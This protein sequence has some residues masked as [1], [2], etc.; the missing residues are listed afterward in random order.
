MRCCGETGIICR[1]WSGEMGAEP[2]VA[3]WGVMRMGCMVCGDW[4]LLP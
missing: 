2:G 3:G 4:G 1:G